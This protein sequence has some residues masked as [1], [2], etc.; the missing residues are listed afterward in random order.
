MDETRFR[1]EIAGLPEDVVLAVLDALEA[2][3]FGERL[4]C[5]DCDCHEDEIEEYP[6]ARACARTVCSRAASPSSLSAGE[7]P[8]SSR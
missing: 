7:N 1:C 3:G 2:S 8:R 4:Y 6:E 5:D